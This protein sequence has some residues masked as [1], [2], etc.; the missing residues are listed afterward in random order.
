MT[1]GCTTT[2]YNEPPIDSTQ[3][4]E[5]GTVVYS[6]DGGLALTV[7]MFEIDGLGVVKV[8]YL[9]PRAGDGEVSIILPQSQSG[10]GVRYACDMAVLH[11]KGDT[12]IAAFI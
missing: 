4:V 6:C 8:T 7:D 2:V 9:S 10:S 1:G 3:F 12:G 5:N 11:L